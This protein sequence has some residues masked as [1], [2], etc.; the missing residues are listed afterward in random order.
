MVVY[1]LVV[2][3][4]VKELTAT[5]TGDCVFFSAIFLRRKIMGNHL[6]RGGNGREVLISLLINQIFYLVR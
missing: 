6:P 4:V 5:I 2:L 1:S 3:L